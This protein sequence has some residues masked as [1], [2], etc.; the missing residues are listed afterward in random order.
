MKR[1]GIL[2]AVLAWAGIGRAGLS[3]SAKADLQAYC[4]KI[5]AAVESHALQPRFFVDLSDGKSK[6]QRWREFKDQASIDK[7]CKHKSCYQTAWLYE[8]NGALVLAAFTFAGVDGDW[9]NNVDYY[10]RP[11]G[12]IAKDHS[13]LRRMGAMERKDKAPQPFLVEVQRTCYYAADGKAWGREE[14]QYFKVEESGKRLIAAPDFT[15]AYWP[16]YKRAKDLPMV[17][18]WKKK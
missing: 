5:A 18:A 16:Q 10:F 9:V 17:K 14:P 7:A 3:P 13:E 15:D 2:L 12:R 6:A 11:G 1:W 8:Q 4:A